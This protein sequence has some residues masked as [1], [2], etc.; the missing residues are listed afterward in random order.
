[1]SISTLSQVKRGGHSLLVFFGEFILLRGI[2][3]FGDVESFSY[4]WNNL[5]SSG[6][7][8]D[9]VSFCNVYFNHISIYPT[10]MSGG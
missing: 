10:L 2:S 1:M 6:V 8:D 7:D 4:P 9:T 5:A 3:F